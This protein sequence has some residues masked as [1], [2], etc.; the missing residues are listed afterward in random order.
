MGQLIK[1]YEDNPAERQLNTIVECLKDGGVIIYPTDTVY[2]I[3]CDITK[4]KAVERVAQLKGVKTAKANFSFICYDL[5]HITDYTKPLSNSIFK[6]MKRNLPGPFTFILEANNKVPKILKANRKTVGIRVP[7]NNIIREIVNLLG[8]PIL[9]TSLKDDDEILE[10]TTDPELIYEDYKNLVDFVIDGGY[11]NNIASTVV[12][13]T[14]DEPEI[15]R[16][17]IGELKL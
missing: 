4:P 16:L 9:T 12:D 6:L 5:S 17:G 8:N 2:G 14:N 11:G 3:G 1:I 15:I 13:C 10:Y 7:A